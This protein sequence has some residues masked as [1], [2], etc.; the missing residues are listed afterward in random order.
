M[1]TPVRTMLA[2][3]PLDR[4]QRDQ[5]LVRS[6]SEGWVIFSKV[7]VDVCEWT[8]PKWRSRQAVRGYS[9]SQPRP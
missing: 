6:R 5:R 2:L 4:R 3:M 9:A 7:I 1:R 8:M